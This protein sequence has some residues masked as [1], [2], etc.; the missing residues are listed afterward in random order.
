M[1]NYIRDNEVLKNCCFTAKLFSHLLVS[2]VNFC[3]DDNTAAANDCPSVVVNLMRDSKMGNN[4][5][6]YHQF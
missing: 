2:I 4:S 6:N 5:P 1:C 3:L